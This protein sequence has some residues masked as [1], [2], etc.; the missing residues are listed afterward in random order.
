MSSLRLRVVAP[1]QAPW[2]AM[3]GG[4]RERHCARCSR[5][6]HNLSEMR[7]EDA[8]RLLAGNDDRLCVRFLSRR[9]GTVVCRPRGG[10][11]GRAARAFA[12]AAVAIGF[13]TAVVLVQRPWRAIARRIAGVPPPAP[14]PTSTREENV[15]PRYD[16]ETLGKLILENAMRDY[17]GSA[18]SM[19]EATPPS[20]AY[21]PSL[22]STWP[23][24]HRH[25]K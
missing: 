20:G 13:W 14:L 6:V 12:V 1:C 18:W 10:W 19:G 5:T 25:R 3:A 8:R 17:G 23:T 22:P 24:K 11:I 7:E 4:D 21:F 15:G 16:D 9:D 2:E